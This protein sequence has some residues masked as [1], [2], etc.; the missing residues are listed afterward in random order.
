MSEAIAKFYENGLDKILGDFATALGVVVIFASFL[1]WLWRAIQNWVGGRRAGG[2]QLRAY[3]DAN[4]IAKGSGNY[5]LKIFNKGSGTASNIR[6]EVIEGEKLFSKNELQSRLPYQQ[7]AQHQSISFILGV[8]LSSP[9]TM[10]LKIIWDDQ[11]SKGNEVVR[12]LDVF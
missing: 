4:V 8:T 1:F 9:R 6:I 2:E 3:L 11:V 5:H 12:W 7:L 10:N